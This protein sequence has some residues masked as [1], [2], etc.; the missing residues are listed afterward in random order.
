MEEDK[1]D[2]ADPGA[3]PGPAPETGAQQPPEGATGEGPG[4]APDETKPQDTTIPPPEPPAPE[5]E[6][7][8]EAEKPFSKKGVPAS[9]AHQA[10]E[11][12]RGPH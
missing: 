6:K 9:I 8:K 2:A 7:D 10:V 3:T 12:D 1:K 4:P 5:A 11:P